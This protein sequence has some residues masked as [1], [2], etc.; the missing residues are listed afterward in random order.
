MLLGLM[1]VNAGAKTSFLPLHTSHTLHTQDVDDE[2]YMGFFGS[3][4]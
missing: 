3:N 4:P 1:Q 2:I